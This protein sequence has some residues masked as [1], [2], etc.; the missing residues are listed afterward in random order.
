[1]K[2]DKIKALELELHPSAWIL[3]HGLFF[4][5]QANRLAAMKSVLVGKVV[6]A[7]SRIAIEENR[8][9]EGEL[10]EVYDVAPGEFYDPALS[11]RLVVCVHLRNGSSV[12][13]VYDHGSYIEAPAP[14]V[15]EGPS[16]MPPEPCR[17]A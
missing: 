10:G 12:G 1:M 15:R 16:P 6:R 5:I 9:D 2:T 7:A 11:G 17:A 4:E 14:A 8:V 13:W 3:T